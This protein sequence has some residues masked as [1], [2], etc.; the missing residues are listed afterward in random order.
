MASN[1]LTYTSQ[2]SQSELQNEICHFVTSIMYWDKTLLLVY[3]VM[4][5]LKINVE[6]VVISRCSS[7]LSSAPNKLQLSVFQFSS[8]THDH[9]LTS[10]SA[11]WSATDI[12]LNSSR[13]KRDNGMTLHYCSPSSLKIKVAGPSNMS[14]FTTLTVI[15]PS[16]Q[17]A[18]KCPAKCLT[19]PPTLAFQPHS[20]FNV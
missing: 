11:I 9:T 19:L 20:L 1:Y 4:A 12:A 14:V 2:F 13:V 17:L 18:H 3:A 10:F 16:S 15:Y 5:Y 6:Y 8:F 7:V